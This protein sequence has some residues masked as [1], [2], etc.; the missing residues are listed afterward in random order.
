MSPRY[1]SNTEVPTDPAGPEALALKAD[2]LAHEDIAEQTNKK[3]RIAL[4]E[5]SPYGAGSEHSWVLDAA[6]RS[7]E[8]KDPRAEERL[9]R[10]R[11]VYGGKQQRAISTSTLTFISSAV[12][13]PYVEEA[14]AYG[15]RSTAPFALALERL[16]LPPSG[17]NVNWSQISTAATITN[18]TA[19]NAALTASADVAFGSN[20]KDPLVTIAGYLDFSA[21]T[22]DRSGPGVFDVII[23]EELGRAFG[24]R[25]EQQIWAGTGSSGQLVGFTSASLS[26]NSSSTVSTQTM[27]GF[28]SKVADQFQQVSSNLGSPPDLLALAPRRYAQ[29]VAA[30]SALGTHVDGIFPN[31]VQVVVSPAAPVNLGASTNEDWAVLLNRA[32]TPLVYSGSPNIQWQPQNSG[33]GTALNVRGIVYSY[34][35]LGVSRRPSGIGLIKGGTSVSF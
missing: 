6:V 23:G 25:L 10:C 16:D 28:M 31:G 26:G 7:G 24:A 19:E 27:A 12:I 34:V 20:V 11:A 8:I 33:A 17:S 29:F 1:R 32:S 21:Q 2:G 35:A 4:N 13:P 18:Q 9:N 14:I 3:L 5:R 30:S 22:R 15:L